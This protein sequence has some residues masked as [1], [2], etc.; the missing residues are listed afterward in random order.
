MATSVDSEAY[1]DQI[2]PFDDG[3]YGAG[4]RNVPTFMFGANEVLAEANYDDLA[5]AMER[6]LGRV[7]RLPAGTL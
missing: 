2:L 6:F 1:A 3:A 5:R 4:V 7:R